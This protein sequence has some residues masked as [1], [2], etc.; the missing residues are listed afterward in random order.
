M[1]LQL[2]C[3]DQTFFGTDLKLSFK[4]LGGRQCFTR[5]STSPHRVVYVVVIFCSCAKSS[6]A[7]THSVMCTSCITERRGFN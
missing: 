2:L 4:S 1:I 7:A 3:E 6:A 5:L